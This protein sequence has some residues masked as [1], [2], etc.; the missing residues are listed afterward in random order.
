M[1]IKEFLREFDF[2]E[3]FTEED[4]YNRNKIFRSFRK[5]FAKKSNIEIMIVDNNG[6][7]EIDWAMWDYEIEDCHYTEVDVEDKIIEMIE[8]L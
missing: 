8:Q 3:Y 6:D 5:R 2:E 1:T 7:W 4:E